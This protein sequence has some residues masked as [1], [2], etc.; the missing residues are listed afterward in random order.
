M[1]YGC[2]SCCNSVAVVGTYMV[3]CMAADGQRKDPRCTSPMRWLLNDA[4]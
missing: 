1:V 3:I 2:L 4:R